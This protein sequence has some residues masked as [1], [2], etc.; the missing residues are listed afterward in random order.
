MAVARRNVSPQIILPLNFLTTMR[1][2]KM[3]FQMNRLVV[4]C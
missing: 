1:A 4:S 3:C 2:F